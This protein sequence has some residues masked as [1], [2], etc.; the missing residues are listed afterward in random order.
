MAVSVHESEARV[1]TTM[2]G[3]IKSARRAAGLTQEAL[4]RRTELSLQAVGDIERGVVQ[5]PHISSLRQI[6]QAL[7]VPVTQ[8]LEEPAPLASA[9]QDTGQPE[10]GVNH[11]RPVGDAVGVTDTVE[12]EVRIEK[13]R[14]ILAARDAGRLD[15]A[16]ALRAIHEES[17]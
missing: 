16:A 5:D 6:A 4:S 13:V 2:G 9:P 11:L 10:T 7:G 1:E 12:R 14:E 3:R 15:D 17:A 8:L